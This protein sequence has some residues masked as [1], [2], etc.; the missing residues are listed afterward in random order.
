MDAIH[1][2]VADN[3]KRLRE[4]RRLSMEELSRLSGVSKSMLAQI[5]RGEGN[6]TLSSLWKLANGMGVPFDALVTRPKPSYAIIKTADIEPILE[7][8]GRVRN[9]SIFP[10]DDGRRFSVYYMELEPGSR[11]LAEP[12]GRGTVE[13]ISLLSGALEIQAGERTFA[14]TAGEHIRFPGDTPHA[15][16]N[17]HTGQTTLQMILYCP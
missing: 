8:D 16:R 17:T 6:P 1:G 4:A 11:W 9:F 7:D 2:V 13:F 12:H 3:I 14:I 15:Y 5:E 10:D